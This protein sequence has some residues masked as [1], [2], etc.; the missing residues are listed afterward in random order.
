MQ[1]WLIKLLLGVA[2]Q[3]LLMVLRE[4]ASKHTLDTLL[5][6]AIAWVEKLAGDAALSNDDKRAQALQGIE[7]DAKAIGLDVSRSLF[8]LSLELAV[9]QFKASHPP[10]PA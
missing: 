6:F 10:P 7:A 5:Q 2:G 1:A 8:N 9:A 3:I 4:L